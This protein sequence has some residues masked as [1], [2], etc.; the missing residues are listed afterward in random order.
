VLHHTKSLNYELKKYGIRA[1][2]FCPGWVETEFFDTAIESG[3]S[4]PEPKKIKPMLNAKKVARGCLKA[5]KRGKTM[6]VTGWYTKLQHL[7]FKILP[8]PILTR[9]WLGMQKKDKSK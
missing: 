9:I 3:V 6:Y 7:L 8:D 1:T 4:M 2:C 5:S